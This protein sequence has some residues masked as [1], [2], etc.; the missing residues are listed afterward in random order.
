MTRGEVMI[1]R[2]SVP[3]TAIRTVEWAE[4]NTWTYRKPMLGLIGYVL[5]LSYSRSERLQDVGTHHWKKQTMQVV[6]AV[7]YWTLA[8]P[9][10]VRYTQKH[11]TKPLLTRHNKMTRGE[12][13]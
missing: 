11:H 3:A 7:R 8:S 12:S 4:A 10:H 9:C 2:A 6:S 5:A 1:A 13:C